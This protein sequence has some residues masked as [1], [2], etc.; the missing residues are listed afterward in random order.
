LQR[1]GALIV[2]HQN[3]FLTRAEL[4]HSIK[5]FLIRSLTA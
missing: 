2:I 3:A 1:K 4:H 5:Q